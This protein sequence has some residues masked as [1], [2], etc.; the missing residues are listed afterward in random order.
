MIRP[1]RYSPA[2]FEQLAGVLE[3]AGINPERVLNALGIP[4]TALSEALRQLLATPPTS[5]SEEFP[6]TSEPLATE[7]TERR[8]QRAVAH[9]A[10]GS[11]R[12]LRGADRREHAT[13]APGALKQQAHL[14]LRDSVSVTLIIILTAGAVLGAILGSLGAAGWITGLLAA[15]LTVVLSAVLRSFSRSK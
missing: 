7:R 1:V 8:R 10:P 5:D 13:D 12:K 3:Q 4:V 9:E 2:E 6:P 15:G 14:T 11:T